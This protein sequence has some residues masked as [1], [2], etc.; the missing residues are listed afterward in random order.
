MKSN[1]RKAISKVTASA[2]MAMM[3]AGCLS[4]CAGGSGGNGGAKSNGK[5]IHVYAQTNGLGQ[6]W[7]KNAAKAYQEKTGTKVDVLFDTY[8]STNIRTTLETEAADVADLYFVQTPEWSS[9]YLDGLIEDMTDFMDEKGGSGKSLNDRMVSIKKYV[10]ND[11]GEQREAFVPLTKAPTGLVYNKK[12][13]SYLCHDVLGWEA[14]HEYPVNTKELFEVI[15]ALEQTTKK[16]DKSD[17]FTYSQNGATLDVKP[18][19]WSGSTG[20]LEFFTYAWLDQY[21]GETGWEAFYNQFDNCDML[22]DEGMYLV[23]QTMMDLLKLEEDSNG[24]WISTTSVPNCVSFNHT[25]AQS[26]ILMNHAVMCPTGSW[27]YSEMKETI[28]DEDNF[29]FM[30]IPYLSDEEGNPITDEVVEMPKNEDGSYMNYTRI[31]R[32]DFFIIPSRISEEE[33][34]NAKDFLRFM[35]S[36][37][38]MPILQTDLQALLCFEFDDSTVE[39]TAWFQSV[40]EFMEKTTTANNYFG[41]K[42]QI[43]D[44][45][46]L[47]NNPNQA[48][49]SRLSISGFGSSK[50]MVDSATGK[51]INNVGNAAGIAVTENVYN[52][53]YNNYKT[54][55]GTWGSVKEFLERH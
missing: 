7:L 9:M 55:A 53:V 54:A 45:I 32:D 23:Y 16:G 46:A 36:E 1:I 11:A 41:T 43:Y 50:K 35:F 33:K 19:V 44:K 30:P 17:L 37:E 34:E 27:F 49:F 5:T 4:G 24:E 13:M 51:E 15:D 39:K 8:I 2:L 26:Q 14:D 47:Y 48:P 10:L 25:S 52:Y 31:N 6:D 42:L 3:V 40:T 38:Y 22:N 21:W 18:F 20:M 28:T 12:M 29:G